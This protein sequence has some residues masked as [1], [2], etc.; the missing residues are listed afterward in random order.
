MQ[1]CVLYN[2]FRIPQKM[3]ILKGVMCGALKAVA[4]RLMVSR[5]FKAYVTRRKRIPCS[6]NEGEVRISESREVT[7]NLDKS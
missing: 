7:V 1:V 2:A 3:Y 4:L 6:R 5:L